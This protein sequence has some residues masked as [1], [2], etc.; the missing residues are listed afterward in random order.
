MTTTSHH[1]NV[2]CTFCNMVVFRI[3][4]D[5]WDLRARYDRNIR[6]MRHWG[7]QDRMPSCPTTEK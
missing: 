7:A 5:R 2:P 1:E 6:P 3:M 4:R